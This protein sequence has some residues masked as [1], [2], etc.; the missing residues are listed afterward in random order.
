MPGDFGGPVCSCAPTTSYAH[1]TAGA[2]CTR[3][4]RAPFA[5]EGCGNYWQTSSNTCC[6]IANLCLHILRRPC[7]R[8]DPST[9]GG[10]VV[11]KSS[12]NRPH[13]KRHGVWVPAFAG[14]TTRIAPPYDLPRILQR[15][16]HR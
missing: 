11:R 9:T 3:H 13:N 15:A 8:R 10:R 5:L 7:E 6:E 16:G 14:T 2:P 1:E 4:S 12:N